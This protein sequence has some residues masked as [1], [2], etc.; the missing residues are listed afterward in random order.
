MIITVAQNKS[1]KKL[2]TQHTMVLQFVRRIQKIYGPI[3]SRTHATFMPSCERRKIKSPSHYQM[4]YLGFG[5]IP[6]TLHDEKIDL[7]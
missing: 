6:E 1:Y 5:L 4:S 2:H 3:V 7:L